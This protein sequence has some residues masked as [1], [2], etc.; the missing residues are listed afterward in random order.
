VTYLPPDFPPDLPPDLV[1][2][3]Q[4]YAKAGPWPRSGTLAE[5][6]A[7]ADRAVKAAH[8]C[9]NLE[10]RYAQRFRLWEEIAEEREFFL[11]RLLTA[12]PAGRA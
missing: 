4:A 9:A 8:R 3:H 11:H 6:Q 1:G 2:R 12:E 10:Y 7:A 5:Y